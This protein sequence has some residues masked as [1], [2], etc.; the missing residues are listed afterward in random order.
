MI[1]AV[2]YDLNGPERNRVMIFVTGATGNVGSELMTRYVRAT[3]RSK[4]AA[5][6]AVMLSSESKRLKK[7][8][9]FREPLSLIR[10]LERKVKRTEPVPTFEHQL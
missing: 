4:R 7:I 5:V 3:E 6:E 8:T 10:S 2:G 1:L 9:A